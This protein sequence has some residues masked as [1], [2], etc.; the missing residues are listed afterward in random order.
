MV[1]GLVEY[2]STP[3]LTFG[4]NLAAVIR[5]LSR[6]KEGANLNLGYGAFYSKGFELICK[7]MLPI[8][9]CPKII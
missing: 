7:L 4:S 3:R 5:G 8:L 9:P 1:G 6:K 2:Y